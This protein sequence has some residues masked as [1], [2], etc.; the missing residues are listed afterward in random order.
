MSLEGWKA[1]FEIGGVILLALTFVFGAGALIVN[2]RLNKAQAR[3][4]EA[5]KLKFEEEQQK[6]ALAQKQAA[7]A[8]QIAGTFERDIATANER[9]AKANESAAKAEENLGN[10]KK[11]AALA[12]Q[13]AADA[14]RIAEEERLKRIQ[15]E[16]RMKPR[17]FRPSP[18]VMSSLQ[19]YKGTEYTFS[20]VFGDEES[21]NLLKQLDSILL[22]AGWIR[23]KP[24]HAYPAINVYGQQQDF[25]VAS[26]LGSSI[27]ISVDSEKPLATLQTIPVNKLPAPAGAAVIL[28][29]E[30]TSGLAPPQDGGIKVNVE[31][32]KSMVVRI[33]VGRKP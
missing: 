16:E 31:S 8:K 4:L 7:E 6:T 21:I 28:A 1:F 22:S 19:A 15:I 23:V 26:G 25:A 33:E 3:E 12:L 17:S 18:Q 29:M 14:N 9:A 30:L 20:S 5:F 10:A 32:G 13:H 11:D 27:K 24:A 2:N